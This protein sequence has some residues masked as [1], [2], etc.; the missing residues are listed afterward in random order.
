MKN[1]IVYSIV[2]FPVILTGCLGSG[3]GS[4][5]SSSPTTGTPAISPSQAA[6]LSAAG[7]TVAQNGNNVDLT[8]NGTTA[9]LTA[10]TGPAGS[11][12]SNGSNGSVGATGAQGPQGATGA[13][14]PQGP[15]GATGAQGPQ[16]VAGNT[17]AQGAQGPQGATGATGAAGPA[18]SAL[19]VRDANGTVKNYL[20]FITANGQYNWFL[21]TSTGHIVGYTQSN[22]GGMRTPATVY[23]SGAGC[24]GTMMLASSSYSGYFINELIAFASD[25]YSVTSYATA[26]SPYLSYYD[27]SCH[28]TGGSMTAGSAILTTSSLQANEYGSVVGPV[29]LSVN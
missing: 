19:V 25:Y 18:G 27:T 26:G 15:A 1:V 10:L 14:G 24:T 11:N 22:I 29:Q 7:C 2:L 3:G 9:T 12:G 4:S 8:C 28:G 20:Q 23:F 21:N 16:G 17:G 6:V 5:S 13:Q